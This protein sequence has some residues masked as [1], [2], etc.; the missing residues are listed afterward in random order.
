MGTAPHPAP[1]LAP[2]ILTIRT[3]HAEHSYALFNPQLY[4]LT[5][6]QGEQE[7]RI[8]LGY[9][10]SRLLERLLLVP[11]AVVSREELLSFAWSDRVVGSG[12]LNQQVYTLRQA[13]GDDKNREIIQTLPRR[14][15]QIN[16]GYL[17]C[18]NAQAQ[19]TPGVQSAAHSHE[20]PPVA[21]RIT[22]PLLQLVAGFA[23]L[24][25]LGYTGL[26]QLTSASAFTSQ[27]R[28]SNIDLQL[29]EQSPTRLEQMREA[30]LQ[31]SL[32]LNDLSAQG[33]L[34]T[35]SQSHGFY[36]L[37]CQRKDRSART[38]MFHDSQLPQ[39]KDEQLLRCVS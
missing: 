36:Q 34:L 14:G 27:Q 5:L 31:L 6:V 7:Q 37:I 18:P 25:L 33:T 16:P 39:L 11:G 13:L 35:L 19:T 28:L 8:D 2:H 32:R 22:K 17:A 1:S 29:I 20:L 9:S 30:S 38:F 24:S 23:A 21:G 26:S 3:G 12:S 15:Y 10:G 4:Q